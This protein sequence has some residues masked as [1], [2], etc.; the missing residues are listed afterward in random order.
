MTRFGAVQASGE[1]GALSA[2][3]A[4]STMSMPGAVPTVVPGKPQ[5]ATVLPRPKEAI[6]HYCRPILKLCMLS[7]KKMGVQPVLEFWPDTFDVSQFVM[8]STDSC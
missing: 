6:F 3:R 4:S 1:L 8:K 7:A 5:T 2:A